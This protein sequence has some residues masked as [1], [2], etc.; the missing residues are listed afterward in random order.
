MTKNL[1]KI[2]LWKK[3]KN[4]LPNEETASFIQSSLFFFF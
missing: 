3:R 1:M 4:P 2:A